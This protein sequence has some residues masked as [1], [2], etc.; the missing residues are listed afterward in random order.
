M[1][2]KV[3]KNARSLEQIE[4]TYR[5]EVEVGPNGK[6]TQVTAHRL[7]DLSEADKALG[8]N[9]GPAPSI[10]V[11]IDLVKV[12]LNN[13]LEDIETYADGYRAAQ[14]ADAV[15]VPSEPVPEEPTP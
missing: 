12:K 8:N 5:L 14:I 9:L 13:V 11:P 10:N 7:N 4:R 2:L 15:S 3:S 6:A 1:P